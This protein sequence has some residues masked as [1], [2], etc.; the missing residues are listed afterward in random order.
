MVRI[1]GLKRA[2]NRLKPKLRY[3]SLDKTAATIKLPILQEK[4]K[5]SLK[6][7]TLLNPEDHLKKKGKVTFMKRSHKT[8]DSLMAK[9]NEKLSKLG[10]DS[11][12]FLVYSDNSDIS[13]VKPLH[14]DLNFYLTTFK[15]SCEKR[16]P[17]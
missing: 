1:S 13:S 2:A 15:I 6:R 9:L 12:I 7:R 10:E 5:D 4:R 17:T 14:V 8:S 16:P 11:S 3:R